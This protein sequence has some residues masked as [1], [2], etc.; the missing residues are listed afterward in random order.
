MSRFRPEF[1][2]PLALA[3]ACVALAGCSDRGN[4]VV[5]TE[6]ESQH[7]DRG[8]SARD[9]EF[10]ETDTAGHTRY[11]LRALRAHQD[12][13]TRE[14]NLQ[15]VRMEVRPVDGEPWQVRAERGHMPVAGRRLELAGDVRLESRLGTDALQLRTATL[16]YDIDAARVRAPGAVTIRTR[17]GELS[18]HAV[19]VDIKTRRVSLESKVHGLFTP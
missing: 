6:P 12:A 1:F 8:Y 2:A 4:L 3:T 14:V 7:L 11:R 9:A 13:T 19:N 10:I 5:N 17:S 15:G 16:Q 18:A